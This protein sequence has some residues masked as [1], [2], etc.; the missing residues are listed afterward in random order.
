MN[1]FIEVFFID[2]YIS[3]FLY[4]V[5]IIL[6][7]GSLSFETEKRSKLRFLLVWKKIIKIFEA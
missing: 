4:A 5:Y 2:V 3:L 1:N 7:L 6:E